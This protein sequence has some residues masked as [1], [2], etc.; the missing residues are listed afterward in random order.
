MSLWIEFGV[1]EK[2]S[3]S[4]AAPECYAHQCKDCYAECIGE[5]KVVTEGFDVVNSDWVPL[6]LVGGR[7]SN[8]GSS[9]EGTTQC[10]CHA[11]VRH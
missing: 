6:G 1:Y 8:F 2:F 5:V 9:L 4:A 3:Q 7:Q 11:M 10:G